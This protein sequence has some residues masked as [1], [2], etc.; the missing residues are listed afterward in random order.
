MEVAK[1]LCDSYFCRLC[2]QEN[3]NSTNLFVHG[4][5]EQDLSE[6]VNKYLPLKVERDGKF[7]ILI[8]PGCN[9]QLEATKQFLDLIIEG[10]NKLRDLFRIQQDTLRRQEKQ[11]L[12]LESALKNV[13]SSST[14][15]T[16]TIEADESGEKFVIQIFSEGPL[17][18]PEHEMSLKAE[19]LERPKRKR[20]RPPKLPASADN[21]VEIKE[22]L[23]P[24]TEQEEEDIDDIENRRKRKIKVP[25]RFQEAVQGKE[26]DR[27]FKEEGVLGEDSLSEDEN[28]IEVE[29]NTQS[30]E[31]V[32]GHLQSKEGEDLGELVI[33]NKNTNKIRI[34][35][36]DEP[37]ITKRKK[38][39]CEICRREFLHNGRYEA[40]KSFH[41]NMKYKCS[42]SE[43]TFEDVAESVIEEHQKESGHSGILFYECINDYG[44]KVQLH[45][46]KIE[47]Y[48]LCK[49]E[50]EEIEK[51]I[52]VPI[53]IEN[54]FTCNICNKNFSCKQNFEIHQ[55][56]VHENQRPYQC[57]KCEKTFPYINSLKCH[58]LQHSEKNEKLYIC[59][60]CK[61]VFNHPSSLVYHREAEHNNGRK[62][63]CNICNKSFKHKQLLQRHQLV[64]SNERPHTCKTCDASF[65]T[66]ANLL[67]HMPIH[68]G[69]KKHNC[70]QCS[71]TFAHKT[72]LTLHMRWHSGQKPYE[73]DVCMKTFSQKGNL[74]EHKRIH[75]GEKPYCCDHCGRKFT[76]SSQFKLHIKRH[77]GERPWRCE[78]CSKTFLHKNTWMCHTRRHRNERPY[79]CKQCLRGF[80]E[81]WA[82]KKHERLHTGEKPYVCDICQRS[83]ADCSNLTK[84]K[85]VH[86][87]PKVD[88][89]AKPKNLKV[90][91]SDGEETLVHIVDPLEST[92]SEETDDVQEN[93]YLSP[94]L[95][96]S[97]QELMDEDG[98]LI[99]LTTAD[100]QPVR[101]LVTMEDGQQSLQ[102]ITSNG[103][104]M[105]ITLTLHNGKPVVTFT[106]I[107]D[108]IKSIIPEQELTENQNSPATNTNTE[109]LDD[110][111][112]FLNDE[113]QTKLDNSIQFLTEDGQ[114]ICF[115][116]TYIDESI[117]PHYLAI[118]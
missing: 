59:E 3:R 34:Q 32:I 81:Q 79:Q 19:G 65:K 69:E 14:V 39:T 52:K 5:N 27:I 87:N 18:P 29:P 48:E 90:I 10:Q 44:S 110:N 50:H 92:Q 33:V 114:N 118:A 62:C 2:A 85:K 88:R 71:Q 38:Y 47:E 12:Q 111:I 42:N 22:T 97:F 64:H 1:L 80:T 68:T 75:T 112:Q 72:S 26:L 104:L 107:E 89:T 51:D 31:E 43:C 105:P 73:C 37:G 6:L 60:V 101:V 70:T 115:V 63:V 99:N 100:G 23:N 67:N 98:S 11:K 84:H 117:N 4:E 20:G 35:N 45:L 16:Y 36:K 82:L 93:S 109:L 94:M 54:K 13:N 113:A 17:F 66:R 108:D 8:C 106:P 21:I 102:G 56:A 53:E 91:T 40:H 24:V 15:E 28:H 116:T 78:Y 95:Q 58:M 46:P 41:K 7:P 9:I 61:K 57:D 55:K 86:G 74:A 25:S 96:D 30:N 83:F 76:T 49:E 77:T 103:T